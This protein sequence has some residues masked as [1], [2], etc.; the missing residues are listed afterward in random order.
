MA[1]VSS[2]RMIAVA[3]AIAIMPIF[4]RAAEEP[5]LDLQAGALRPP[6][7]DQGQVWTIAANNGGRAAA[8]GS[9]AGWKTFFDSGVGTGVVIFDAVP[10]FR[11]ASLA[12]TA[13]ASVQLRGLGKGVTAG[14]F[15]SASVQIPSAPK[16]WSA[17]YMPNAHWI[18][19][20]LSGGA[21][22]VQLPARPKA[23]SGAGAVLVPQVLITFATKQPSGVCSGEND[24]SMNMANGVIVDAAGMLLGPGIP[25]GTADGA[26][27]LAAVA[28]NGRPG[29]GPLRT[30]AFHVHR[31][32]M[33]FGR[34][35]C[36]KQMPTNS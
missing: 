27:S 8:Y 11:G 9:I 5:R 12:L 26:V 15:Y 31:H 14:F 23:S 25:A 17:A 2:F 16:E 29:S 1:S 36:E 3:C 10:R 21:G 28:G 7:P 20:L 19:L 6:A 13:P 18:A 30:V 35:R 22:N 24:A 4:A 33:I 32:W 34:E